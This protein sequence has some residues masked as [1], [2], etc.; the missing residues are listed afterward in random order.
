MLLSHRNLPEGAEY[1]GNADVEG[2]SD[3]VQA[4]LEVWRR[5]ALADGVAVEGVAVV[6]TEP[7]AAIVFSDSSAWT[8]PGT[9][10]FFYNSPLQHL[11]DTLVDDSRGAGVRTVWRTVASAKN[12]VLTQT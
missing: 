1:V 8:A 3:G 12:N 5:P 9:T 11:G 10:P 6:N 2:V 4:G 7:G